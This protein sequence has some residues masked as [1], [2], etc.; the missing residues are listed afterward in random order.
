VA[1][2]SDFAAWA[3]WPV[4]FIVTVTVAWD[5]LKDLITDAR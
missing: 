2:F 4:V 1:E 5:L 3:I